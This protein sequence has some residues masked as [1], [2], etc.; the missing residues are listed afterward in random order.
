MA[1][2]TSI[3]VGSGLDLE[4]LITNLLNAERTPTETRLA[5]RE[6]SI[7]ANISAFGNLKSVLSAFETSLAGLRSADDFNAR[8]ASVSDTGYFSAS[9]GADA[10]VG[11]YSIQ[12]LN[13]ASAQKLASGNFSG[14]DD[15]VGSGTLTISAA[16]RSIDIE[17]AAG[18]TLLQLRDAINEAPGNDLATATLLTVDDGL[19][20]TVTKLILTARSSGEDNALEITV[21]DDD[22][23]DTDDQGLSRFYFSAGDT[24][25]QL[26]ELGSARDARIAVDG[27]TASSST[28]TFSGVLDGV[29]ITALRE[30]EDPLSPEDA[31]L[32]VGLNTSRIGSRVDDFVKAYNEVRKLITQLTS[33]DQTTNTAGPLLGDSTVRSIESGLRRILSESVEGTE[34]ISTLSAIG[35]E[36]QR[37]GTLSVDKSKLNA[38]LDENLDEVVTLFTADNGAATRLASALRNYLGTGG[39]L[40]TRTDGFDAQLE[41]ITEQR[42]ALGLRLDAL[43][44]QFRARFTALDA[45]VAQLQ[46]SGDFLLAQLENTANII[47]RTPG[48]NNTSG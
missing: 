48:G 8:S 32:S 39:L 24:G 11:S 47:G 17:V 28:N 23:Q 21:D 16:G 33:Y 1:G 36:T 35:I 5:V 2:I 44:S 19:G 9:A 15:T 10:V 37:D 25:S 34:T 22:G 27:F 6:A 14:S 38:A 29:T 26:S 4:S 7:Q 18:T 42:E 46:R 20:G 30:P 12:V 40:P 41:R 3:G 31:T 13:L 43:E 45:L